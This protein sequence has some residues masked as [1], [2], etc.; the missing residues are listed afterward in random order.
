M[1]PQQGAPAERGERVRER[2]HRQRPAG[3][4]VDTVDG[5]GQLYEIA[6]TL[7]ERRRFGGERG[8]VGVERAEPLAVHRGEARVGLALHPV[9]GREQLPRDVAARRDVAV[10]LLAAGKR[11]LG[12]REER[13]G[14]R[15]RELLLIADRGDGRLQRAGGD[16]PGDPAGGRRG[17]GLPRG[18]P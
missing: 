5:G 6:C 7:G 18:S 10:Q 13:G 1:P 11:G 3:G 9:D 4:Q 12:G 17:A 8:S 2:P 14:H 15:V 16:E